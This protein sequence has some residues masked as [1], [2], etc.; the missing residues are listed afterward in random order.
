MKKVVLPVLKVLMVGIAFFPMSTFVTAMDRSKNVELAPTV[1]EKLVVG[2]KGIVRWEKR[3]AALRQPVSL[4]LPSKEVNRAKTSILTKVINNFPGLESIAIMPTVDPLPGTLHSAYTVR[5]VLTDHLRD[6][7]VFPH[8]K[9]IHFRSSPAAILLIGPKAF[10]QQIY[11][12]S[13]VDVNLLITYLGDKVVL[14]INKD[15]TLS[16]AA[17]I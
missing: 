1:R 7:L 17:D 4:I 16:F 6:P 12:L 15:G 13:K 14:I 2:S 9:P 5:L 3:R 11:R 10:P 8:E